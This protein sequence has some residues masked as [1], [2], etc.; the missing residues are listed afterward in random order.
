MNTNFRKTKYGNYQQQIKLISDS[1]LQVSNMFQ[2]AEF[3][4][5]TSWFSDEMIAFIEETKESNQLSQKDFEERY[6]A[7]MQICKELGRAGWVISEHS[8]PREISEWYQLLKVD[9][10]G[11]VKYFDA[12]EESRIQKICRKLGRTYNEQPYQ[13][14]FERA[15]N[16][17][18]KKDYM[19]S[20]MY[21][22]ALL[23]VRVNM[24]MKYPSNIKKYSQKF[25]SEGF[26][27][28]LQET[29]KNK[30]SFF[31]KRILFL[32]MYPSIIEFLNRTFVDG[33]YTFKTG[34][35]PDYVNR[36]WILHGRSIREVQRYEC[37][38]LI[39][40]LSAIEFVFKLEM[41]K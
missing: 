10:E 19:T 2:N 9:P 29:F 34:N 21:L 36:N 32:E 13:R 28:Y 35:E 38:Q 4:I 16:F 18:D 40:A 17:F 26:E 25:S 1:L 5:N 22:V 8:N 41:I 14:Y 15:I 39:N 7:E 37:I 11:I 23:E 20:A 3:I 31:V 27:Q 6:F 12:E 33:E 24:L 30:N